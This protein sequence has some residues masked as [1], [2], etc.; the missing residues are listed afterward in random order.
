MSKQAQ[1]HKAKEDLKAAVKTLAGDEEL[2]LEFVASAE[3]D[4]FKW[5]QSLV[6]GE[7]VFTIPEVENGE[8]LLRESRAASDMALCYFLFH[9]RELQLDSEPSLEAQ[10]FLNDFEKIRILAKME[11]RYLGCTENILEKI[12]EDIFLGSQNLSLVLLN[13]IFPDKIFTR[14]KD[15]AK[16]LGEQLPPKIFT[17]IEIL[18]QNIENQQSFLQETALLLELLKE[19]E[20]KEESESEG[21]AEGEKPQTKEEKIESF[22]A[23]TAG[24][25][26]PDF[27]SEDEEEALQEE[28]KPQEEFAEIKEGESDVTI[29][30]AKGESESTRAKIEFIDAYKIFSAKFDEVVYPQKL[31]SKHDLDLLWHQLELKISRLSDISRKMSLKLRKALLS[32][33][34]TVTDFDASRGVL[35]RKKLTR[36]VIDP[37]IEDIWV[38]DREH[39]YQ[40]T[41][42]TILLDNSGSMRG[43]PI[44][45]SALA[46]KI[47]AEIL[48]K[49]SVKVE[50]IGFTTVDWKGGRARKVWEVEGRPKNPGRL[51][52][53]RHIIYKSFNQ[54]FKKS[55]VNLGLMLKEGVLKENI[56]GEALLFARSRL[57]QQSEQR[58][59]LMVISDGTPI[60]DSTLANN[61]AEILSNHLTHVV[62]RIEKGGKVEIVGIG[63]GHDT[64]NFYKNSMVIK[65]LEDLGDVMINKICE[66]L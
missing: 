3:N 62:N 7:N 22:G 32:K 65:N 10:K 46:C 31:V 34:S 29:S 4:F 19:D 11:G 57:M 45:M 14:T 54:N 2:K 5:D 15:F 33:R 59:I 61:D 47:I 30:K 38:S 18:A 37:M 13:K 8:V 58:K 35:N 17:Q 1:I 16:E 28:Q 60:D 24:E 50:I 52:D 48:E 44:V 49:F 55:K 6:V 41:A 25:N 56:D 64:G 43:S 42:L 26:N 66:I 20:E 36:I 21:E 39:E 63:I 40:N 27:P 9:D 51:T 12:E 53:L 23:E